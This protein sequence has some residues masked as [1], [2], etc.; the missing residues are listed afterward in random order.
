MTARNA[1]PKQGARAHVKAD[2]KPSVT[3]LNLSYD[4]STKRQ[5]QDQ[6]RSKGP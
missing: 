6:K 1:V 3:T 4:L 2:T 5:K